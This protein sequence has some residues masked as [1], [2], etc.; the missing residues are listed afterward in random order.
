MDKFIL[1][2]DICYILFLIKRIERLCFIKEVKR[3]KKKKNEKI[4]VYQKEEKN[5]N[6]ITIS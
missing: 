1:L 4:L 5:K 3:Y 6:W 2:L